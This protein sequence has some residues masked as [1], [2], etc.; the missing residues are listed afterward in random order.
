MKF[1]SMFRRTLLVTSAWLLA[2]S[3]TTSGVTPNAER[4]LGSN[5]RSGDGI[6][7]LPSDSEGY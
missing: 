2:V 7:D 1:V 5:F 4:D 6:P 3:C